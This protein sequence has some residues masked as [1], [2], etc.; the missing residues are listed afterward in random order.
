MKASGIRHSLVDFR[1]WRSSFI[2]ESRMA[3]EGQQEEWRPI[4]VTGNVQWLDMRC[5]QL[6]NNASPEELMQIALFVNRE[7]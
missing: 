1:E 7:T 6:K 5:N 3:E 2:L 4:T